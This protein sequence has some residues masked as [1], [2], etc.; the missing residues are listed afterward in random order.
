LGADKRL[1]KRKEKTRERG[2]GKVNGVEGSSDRLMT[3][4]M[5]KRKARA[6]GKAGHGFERS[7]V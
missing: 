6:T 1:E 2:P 7:P 5:N 4:G 3:S